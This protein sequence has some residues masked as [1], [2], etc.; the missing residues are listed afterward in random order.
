MGGVLG[1]AVIVG[2]V[3]GVVVDV[4][5][6]VVVDVELEV[7]EGVGGVEVDVGVLQRSLLQPFVRQAVLNLPNQARQAASMGI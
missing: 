3:L 7:D 2:G 5:L 1:V 6:G 4:E